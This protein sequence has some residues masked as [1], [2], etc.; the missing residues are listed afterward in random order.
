MPK[1]SPPKSRP[2]K[3]T[4]TQLIVLSRAAQRDDGA[5]AVPEGMPHRAA[6]RLAASLIDKKLAREVKATAGKPVWRQSEEEGHYALIITKLGR[7]A[8]SVADEGEAKGADVAEAKGAEDDAEMRTPEEQAP[9]AGSE[10]NAPRSGSKLADVIALLDRD[11][12]A[13]IAE[14]ISVTGWLPHT[15]RA[16]LTGLRK[17]GYTVTRQR[18][19]EGGSV[20][21]IVASPTQ[22]A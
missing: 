1:L 14:L 21:R 13:S 3:L 7:A 15:T 9:S 8:I 2:M 20:Y 6:L 12:G 4:D 5:A 16:A 11:A 18:T 17:R 10:P 22:A 19:E